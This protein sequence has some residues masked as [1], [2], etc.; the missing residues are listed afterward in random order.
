MKDGRD[1]ICVMEGYRFGRCMSQRRI[2]ALV[3]SVVYSSFD[4]VVSLDGG[5]YMLDNFSFNG[6][7]V[8]YNAEYGFVFT[9]ENKNVG[10]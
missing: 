9:F 1:P 2:C 8:F 4:A 5:E 7:C 3:G 6:R 10:D